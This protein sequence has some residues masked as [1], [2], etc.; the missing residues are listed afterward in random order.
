MDSPKID[1][2]KVISFLNEKWQG[3]PCPLCGN[4]RWSVQDAAFE[5]R[6]FHGGNFVLGGGAIIPLV[7]VTCENCGYTALINAIKAGVVSAAPAQP[8]E[9]GQK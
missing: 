5:L 6:Q 1:A 3:R 4:R 2:T 9:G 8:T 7:P